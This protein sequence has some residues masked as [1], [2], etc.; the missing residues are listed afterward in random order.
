MPELSKAIDI[1][2]VG[3]GAVVERYYLPEL[4]DLQARGSVR[5]KALYDPNPERIALLGDR[6]PDASRLGDLDQIGGAGAHLAIVASPAGMHAEHTLAALQAGLHVLC[7]KPMAASVAEAQGMIDAARERGRLLAIGLS[8]R[9]FPACPMIKDVLRCDLLGQ[10]ESFEFLEGYTFSWPLTSDALFRKSRGGGGVTLDIGV[11][12]LDQIL[13][14]FG[15]PDGIEY[16]DDAMGGVETNSVIRLSFPSGLSGLIRLSWD[17]RIPQRFTYRGARGW[18]EWRGDPGAFS[19]G[20]GNREYGISSGLSDSGQPGAY[21]RRKSR[22]DPGRSPFRDQ[23]HNV[24]GA[25][26]GQEELW[27]PGEEAIRSLRLVE[28]CYASGSLLES[29][30]LGAAERA[31]ARHLARR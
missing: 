5:V 12:V 16:A 11:H 9:F 25:I 28:E 13:W 8:R 31:E 22:Q 20:L 18:L 19:L 21:M 27:V 7:E 4:S 17:W 1:A 26:C 30:W 15:D 2:I 10:Q 23:L 29:P 3:C 14:W 6:F 24:I